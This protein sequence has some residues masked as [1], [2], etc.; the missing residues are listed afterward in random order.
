MAHDIDLLTILKANEIETFED[1]ENFLMKQLIS[2][3]N[4]GELELGDDK[5]LSG[6]SLELRVK[7]LFEN[8][9]FLIHEGRKGFEDFVIS[10][11][12]DFKTK[13]KIVIEVKSSKSTIVKLDDLRQLDDWVFDLSGEEQLRKRGVKTGGWNCG[14]QT[15]RHPSPHKGLFIFNGPI[16]LSFEMRSE[17]FIHPSQLN[18]LLSRNF[19]AISLQ[20]LI[21]LLGKE[22]TMV[23]ETIHSTVGEFKN[24]A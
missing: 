17:S 22:K 6:L 24:N 20:D 16:G 19:C 21:S 13:D 14:P 23:W 7:E 18:F 11:D 9:G 4:D 15:V 10:P 8:A 12:D 1:A 2:I 3:R 5:N